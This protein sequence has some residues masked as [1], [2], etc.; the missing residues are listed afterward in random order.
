MTAQQLVFISL[1]PW[2]HVWRRNQFLCRELA[3]RGWEVLFIEPASDWSSGLRRAD[4]SEF[5]RH[6]AWSPAGLPSVRVMRPVKVMPRSSTTGRRV[7]ARLLRKQVQRAL[8]RLGWVR[9][10][11]W[12]N[13][14]DTWAL[15]AAGDWERVVYDVT[16]DWARGF[17]D[18]PTRRRIEAADRQL[19]G[20]ADDVIVCSARLCELREPHARR[21]H[22]I[23]NGVDVAAYRDVPGPGETP[24]RS[25]VWRRPVL[26]YTGTLHPERLSLKLIVKLAKQWDGTVVLL[27]PNHL[28]DATQPLRSH[29]NVDVVDAVPYGELPMWMRAMDVMIV[30]HRVT[31]F[32]ESLNP[33]KL[34]EY[35]AAGKPV[36]STPVAGFRDFPQHVRLPE[37]PAQFIGACQQAAGEDDPARV[38]ARQ[39]EAL[40]HDWSRRAEAAEAV[41]LGRADGPADADADRGPSAAP[42]GV[43]DAVGALSDA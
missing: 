41:L 24:P 11:L 15:A 43:D 34:W 19:C 7:N 35:L 12:I 30:P 13:D 9:P 42:L 28:G 10:R 8:R 14:H 23:P 40:G 3:G 37:T 4:W 36:V 26:G 31:E 32:T 38:A 18:G 22:L 29:P 1:E 5:R 27:G 17:D 6:E 33:L 20:I 25:R 2:D 39:A 21:V 16:D